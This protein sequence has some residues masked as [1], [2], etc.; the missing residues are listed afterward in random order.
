MRL[1]S[2][3]AIRALPICARLLD[4]RAASSLQRAAAGRRCTGQLAQCTRFYCTG[5]PRQIDQSRPAQA[6]AR[7]NS[8]LN[9]S[10]VEEL[11]QLEIGSPIFS[12]IASHH[13]PHSARRF[14]NQPSSNLCL[15]AADWARSDATLYPP[16]LIL[17]CNKRDAPTEISRVISG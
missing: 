9:H 4:Q 2:G 15:P 13:S 7:P 11:M 16:C 12:V 8:L 14:S 10:T 1:V 5:S 6:T 17:S 3:K